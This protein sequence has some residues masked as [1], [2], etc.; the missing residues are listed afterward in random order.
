MQRKTIK[1]FLF[2]IRLKRVF[3]LLPNVLKKKFSYVSIIIVVN[4]VLDLFGIALFIPLLMILLD[5]N[6]IEK[7]KVLSNIHSAIPSVTVNQF[8]II[9]LSILLGVVILKNIV[10][11]L[12]SK[13]QTRLLFDVQTE[14]SALTLQ[15]FL[16]SNLLNLKKQN[17]NK[18]IWDVTV[19]PM[20]FTRFL[21]MPLITFVNEIL[22]VIIIGTTLLMINPK[23]VII[24]ITI[25][26]AYVFYSIT[27]K[28]LHQYQKRLAQISPILNSLTQQAVFGY[29]DILLTQT[30]DSYLARYKKYQEE[31]KILNTNVF[32]YIFI[33]AK[34]IETTAILV[35]ILLIVIGI[36]FNDDKESVISFLGLFAI[37]AYRLIPSFNRITVALISFRSYQYTLNRLEKLLK[38]ID[39]DR[40]KKQANVADFTFDKAINLKNIYFEY[41]ANIPIISGV[42]FQ[43]KKGEHVGIIGKSG[44]GKSTLMN[45]ILGV[46][47]NYQGDILVDDE[48]ITTSNIHHWFKKIGYVQQNIFLMDGTIIE[49][50]AF[51]KTGDE[52]DLKKVNKA[53][54]EANLT[55]FINELPNGIET[56]VGELGNLISGGQK[57]RIGIARAIYADSEI[58][59]LDE[60]TSSLDSATESQIIETLN[61][62]SKTNKKMTIITIAHRL[63]T[64]KYCTKIIDLE[65][66]GVETSYEKL[67]HN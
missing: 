11:T 14:I 41:K 27:N 17:S 10:S 24:L 63:S 9:L 61:E 47:T 43:V 25:P 48:K 23:L 58:L 19:L 65:N 30:K 21:V 7:Y 22:I 44:S 35:V 16:E 18:I 49:N 67:M 37:A 4:T 5:D 13:L 60:A 29:I 42:S 6:Y 1:R 52:I 54:K 55:A 2:W 64:L 56:K 51:G 50:I 31:Y 34:I 59:L 39:F 45:I 3:D 62:L 46:I 28:K 15:S 66:G 36:V 57:Q 26:I 33:P 8:T 40:K 20:Y 12:I 53:I 32:T 38:N